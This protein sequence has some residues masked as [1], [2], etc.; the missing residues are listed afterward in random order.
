[1]W[2]IL[3][4]VNEIQSD[5]YD[6]FHESVDLNPVSRLYTLKQSVHHLEKNEM[7]KNLENVFGKFALEIV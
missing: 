2:Q 3:F 5:R 7:S 4:N 6:L 1:M